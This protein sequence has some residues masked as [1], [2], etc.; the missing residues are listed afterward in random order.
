MSENVMDKDGITH[1]IHENPYRTHGTGETL[2]LLAFAWNDTKCLL[3]PRMSWTKN[4]VT[5]LACIYLET[6]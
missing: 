5:C 3:Y 2:C 4:Q 1:A 6:T